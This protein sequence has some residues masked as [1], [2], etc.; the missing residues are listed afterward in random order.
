[1]QWPPP[2]LPLELCHAESS[3]QTIRLDFCHSLV[4]GLP[5]LR[6]DGWT[7]EQ[8]NHVCDVNSQLKFL[9]HFWWPEMS[10]DDNHWQALMTPTALNIYTCAVFATSSFNFD[11]PTSFVSHCTVLLRKGIMCCFHWKSGAELF[12]L[13]WQMTCQRSRMLV[14]IV[15]TPCFCFAS[16]VCF[17]SFKN[18]T[19]SGFARDWCHFPSRRLPYT[20]ICLSTFFLEIEVCVYPSLLTLFVCYLTFWYHMIQM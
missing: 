15:L 16:S 10:S 13:V 2:G 14:Y 11:L 8:Q 9:W 20:S 18:L 7:C 1:M 17:G 12:D 4:S 5:S 3:M 6:R 19:S